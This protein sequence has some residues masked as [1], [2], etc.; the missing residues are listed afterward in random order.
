MC[1]DNTNYHVQKWTLSLKTG[2]TM[3][4]LKTY[5]Q[6]TAAGNGDPCQNVTILLLKVNSPHNQWVV[7]TVTNNWIGLTWSFDAL[8][9]SS[10]E[11]NNFSELCNNE[12]QRWENY[13]YIAMAWAKSATRTKVSPYPKQ[14]SGWAQW[15]SQ[16]ISI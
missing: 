1:C 4:H 10:H 6:D 16:V 13:L 14:D 11:Q 8:Q 9:S 12:D 7:M 15:Y 2:L 3:K 5:H